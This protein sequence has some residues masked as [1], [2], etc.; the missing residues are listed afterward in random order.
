METGLY[1]LTLSKQIHEQIGAVNDE[2]YELT[3]KSLSALWKLPVDKEMEYAMT[4]PKWN[5]NWKGGKLY[6]SQYRLG[7]FT[8]IIK[9]Y[10]LDAIKDIIVAVCDNVSRE[11]TPVGPACRHGKLCSNS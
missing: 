3:L 7:C 10:M 9:D 5:K 4:Q 8:E 11:G 6:I 2:N 1:Y